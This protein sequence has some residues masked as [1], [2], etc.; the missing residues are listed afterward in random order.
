MIYRGKTPPRPDGFKGLFEHRQVPE[1]SLRLLEYIKPGCFDVFGRMEAGMVKGRWCSWH[2]RD[3]TTV[4]LFSL[5]LHTPARTWCLGDALLTY[6]SVVM[7]FEATFCWTRFGVLPY[8]PTTSVHAPP[9][10][11]F[12]GLNI[13]GARLPSTTIP[14]LCVLWCARWEIHIIASANAVHIT[15]AYL[16]RWFYGTDQWAS[17]LCI[18]A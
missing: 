12:M 6:H 2:V 17:T 11:G 14:T 1:A 8:N 5:E 7:M 4:R 13:V 9:R 15:N 18:S 10:V 3:V 16:I